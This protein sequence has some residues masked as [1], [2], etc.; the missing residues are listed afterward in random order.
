MHAP[1]HVQ[2][3]S[4]RR[5]CSAIRSL[6]GMGLDIRRRL[7][8]GL[9]RIFPKTSAKLAPRL[10]ECLAAN[11]LHVIDVGGAFGPDPRWGLFPANFIRF[12]TFEPDAR[13]RTQVMPGGQRN[14][15]LTVG[16]AEAAG[17]KKLHLTEGPFASSLYPPNERVL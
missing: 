5:A 9:D 2:N 1:F 15:T 4:L 17:E 13:S 14:L 11:P 7:V 8:R 12:M 6:S 3:A 10:A 16:L